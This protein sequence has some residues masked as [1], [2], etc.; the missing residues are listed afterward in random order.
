[1]NG[2]SRKRE[3]PMSSPTEVSVLR[4]IFIAPDG[5]SIELD[6]SEHDAMELMTAELKVPATVPLRSGMNYSV[7]LS[8]CA[9]CPNDEPV[10]VSVVTSQ[11]SGP[12]VTFVKN[13][14]IPVSVDEPTRIRLEKGETISLVY[15]LR[16]DA[17]LHKGIQRAELPDP[18]HPERT[19]NTVLATLVMS[20]SEDAV[21]TV[22][23]VESQYIWIDP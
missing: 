7:K 21:T 1:M 15:A 17:I 2:I 22:D 8:N 6:A 13:H 10:Y 4:F 23:K 18:I 12:G 20:C 5:M 16:E 3:A 19:S 14:T 11:I 9:H